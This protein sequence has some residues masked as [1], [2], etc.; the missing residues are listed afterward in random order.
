MSN[1][2]SMPSS[3]EDA[4]EEF[5]FDFEVETGDDGIGPYEFWGQRGWD[6]HPY[7]TVSAEGIVTLQWLSEEPPEPTIRFQTLRTDSKTGLDATVSVE[8][9]GTPV[10]EQTG[11]GFVV[12]AAFKYNALGSHQG[13]P[14]QE[15]DYEPDDYD[16]RNDYM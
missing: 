5:D 9:Q 4:F 10:V 15:R 11:D 16:D 13:H 6:S 12:T 1:L 7:T 14:E 2:T 3:P 8:M